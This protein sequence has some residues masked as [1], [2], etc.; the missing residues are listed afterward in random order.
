MPRTSTAVIELAS[1]HVPIYYVDP[2][3]SVNPKTM[4]VGADAELV[5]QKVQAVIVFLVSFY[6]DFHDISINSCFFNLLLQNA[7]VSFVLKELCAL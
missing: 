4:L 7:K 3:L 5:I 2:T 1:A 6:S